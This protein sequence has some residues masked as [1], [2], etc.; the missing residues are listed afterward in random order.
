MAEAGPPEIAASSAIPPIT[1]SVPPSE[2]A[3]AHHPVAARFAAGHR[4]YSVQA[5][6]FAT[7]SS[8]DRAAAQRLAGAGSASRSMPLQRN[9]AT[10]YRVVVE[11]LSQ[12]P[13][14]PTRR[15]PA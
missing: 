11:A 2:A 10:L 4:R 3:T 1:V 14:P 5:G 8:A 9:G 13:P 15:A 12:T 6:A 7:Q